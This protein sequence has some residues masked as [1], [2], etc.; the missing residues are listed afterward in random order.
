NGGLGR[1]VVLGSDAEALTSF[2]RIPLFAAEGIHSD[3]FSGR[4]TLERGPP[5]QP[6]VGNIV[7]LYGNT[8]WMHVC[9]HEMDTAIEGSLKGGLKL[10]VAWFHE[11]QVWRVDAAKGRIQRLDRLGSI[12]FA[13]QGD[14]ALDSNAHG[15]FLPV[16]EQ[17]HPMERLARCEPQSK[18]VRERDF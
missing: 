11:E 5:H 1:I 10:V 16:V 15:E 13:D 14:D 6:V 4:I 18:S 8:V 17:R 7:Q 2:Q 9:T 12:F 3:W